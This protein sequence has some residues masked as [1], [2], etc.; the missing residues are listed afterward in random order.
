MPRAYDQP[1]SPRFASPNVV[2][3]ERPLYGYSD[4]DRL[5]GLSAGTA[6]RWIDGYKRRKEYPPIVRQS[7][8]G[9]DSVT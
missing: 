4:V 9:V 2:M 1:M 6:R 8:T 3:L 5:L 7:P